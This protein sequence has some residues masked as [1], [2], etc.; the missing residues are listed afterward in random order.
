VTTSS[1]GHHRLKVSGFVTP[2]VAL[3]HERSKEESGQSI[4]TYLLTK[5]DGQW[6]VQSATITQ[7]G[8]APGK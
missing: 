4:R 7:V 1:I 3:V 6:R 8:E 2:D 5:S